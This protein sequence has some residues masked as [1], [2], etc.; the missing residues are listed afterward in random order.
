MTDPAAPWAAN[1]LDSDEEGQMS[2]LVVLRFEGVSEE[3]YWAVNEKLGID[4]DFTRNVPDGLVVHTAGPVGDEGWVVSEVW[5][6]RAEQEA[7][8]ADRLGEALGAVGVPPPAQVITT[9]AVSL[10]LPV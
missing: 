9:D 10:R 6:T 8:M 4:R 1:R 2:H 7:F 3:A 5:E